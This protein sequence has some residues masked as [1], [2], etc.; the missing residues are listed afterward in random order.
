[1]CM[2]MFLRYL[3]AWHLVERLLEVKLI[4]GIYSLD[5]CEDHTT[6]LWAAA[7]CEDPG[8]GF[9]CV[10]VFFSQSLTS[11]LIK[12]LHSACIVKCWASASAGSTATVSQHARF[13]RSGSRLW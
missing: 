3:F 8:L 2:E 13:A 7:E 10:L 9:Q 6:V 11:S 5:I 4:L 1:M 12:A